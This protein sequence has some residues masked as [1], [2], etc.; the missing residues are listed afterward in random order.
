M[1]EQNHRREDHKMMI[2]SGEKFGKYTLLER[3]AAGGMA[4]IYKASVPGRDGTP[5]VVAIKRLHQQFSEDEEFATMLIDEA[6]LAVQ[7]R[8]PNI[9][10]VFD[11]ERI[12][13]QYFIVM[14]Y[15]EGLDLQ[16]LAQ[17]I[18][19]RGHRFPLEA[20]V[21]AGAR[22][23]EALHYA[24]TRHGSDG[25]PLEVVHRDVSPQNIMI[26][27]DGR[28]KLV[29]FGIAKARMRAQHTRAGVIKGKF[30]YMSPEQAHG[31]R[32]DARSDVY[33]LGMV[34]YEVL[35]GGH[36]FED[37]P[38]NELLNSVRSADYPPIGSVLPG[39]PRPM[40]SIVDGA[41]ERSV[42]RRYSSARELQ[43]ALESYG[44]QQLPPFGPR[45][46]T[47][48]MRHYHQPHRG[49]HAAVDR[50]D[51]AAFTTGK[52]SVIFEPG[53]DE[54][55]EGGKT[56]I[57]VRDSAPGESPFEDLESGGATEMLDWKGDV[58]PIDEGETLQ[59][60]KPQFP[61]QSG[62]AS[63]PAEAAG[64]QTYGDVAQK[65][66]TDSARW[67]QVDEDIKSPPRGRFATEDDDGN[68]G[69]ERRATTA[70]ISRRLV[71]NLYDRFDQLFRTHP[72]AIGAGAAVLA[73]LVL[74][75]SAW[76]AW[77]PD[78][79]EESGDERWHAGIAEE[80]RDA[81]GGLGELELPLSTQPAGA[82][83]YLDGE[84]EGQTP[85]SIGPLEAGEVYLLRIERDGYEER[86]L[87]L[88]AEADMAPRV[89]RLEPLGG[90]LR[91]ESTPEGAEIY[92]NDEAQGETPVT[93]MG[94]GREVV[95]VVEARWSD[96]RKTK[97]IEWAEDD[98]RVREVS[99]E[100]EEEEEEPRAAAPRRQPS[101]TTSPRTP[102]P[103]TSGG[104]G[105]QPP[106]AVGDSSSSDS[107]GALNIF[108]GE[109]QTEQG[110][111]N[112]RTNAD[113]GRIY[114]NGQMVQDGTV[115]IGHR[116][117]PGQYEV[118]A[119]FPASGEYSDTRTVQIRP[120]ETST[121]M[122][123]E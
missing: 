6:K 72:E 62:A 5:K 10:Q 73:V 16:E 112:V 108:G 42:E 39:L 57:F 118:R 68:V 3:L 9:G 56:E 77:G 74:G 92:V 99:F 61:G 64:S 78:S 28:V 54:F 1:A 59:G 32:L 75:V 47:A 8:H 36:P 53:T 96:D 14:E 58:D 104:T 84:L 49:N 97:E 119:Y 105:S 20:L 114:V 111:L 24:H 18:Y 69:E 82:S 48:L 113:Q 45:E 55:E 44:R 91:V 122:L 34:L 38:D 29:D 76:V 26:D 67:R 46:M 90:I 27:V 66:M 22:A 79:S 98:E 101:P 52:H 23:A 19:E 89:V 4:E 33:G 70:R 2:E 40:V 11:L 107:G 50:M 106:S 12:D 86:E 41:L 30:Y 31:N 109:E 13:G 83:V 17:R 103:S 117:D 15:I 116:L 71:T 51:P 88:V 121:V 85:L 87:N 65:G 110:R 120:G 7:L 94:L 60:E 115:L 63:T 100:F 21:Y 37:V 95:H 43:K 102:S 93:V 25:A 123:S 80:P 81:D 35:T